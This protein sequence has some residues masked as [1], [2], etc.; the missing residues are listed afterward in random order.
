MSRNVIL[1]AAIVVIAG[2]FY[3]KSSDKQ[4]EIIS[5]QTTQ[6]EVTTEGDSKPAETEDEILVENLI[7][8]GIVARI[9]ED[10]NTPKVYVTA[11]FY[12]IPSV[13]KKNI[14]IVMYKDFQSKNP[15]VTSFTV[16]DDK[17]GDEVGTYDSNG[18]TEK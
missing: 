9:E 5:S 10:G 17:S 3:M 12:R 8:E 15:E 14:L 4:Q 7:K 1:I 13:D 11:D 2:Y 6:R 16:Y 18:F